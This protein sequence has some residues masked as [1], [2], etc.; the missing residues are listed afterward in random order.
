MAPIAGPPFLSYL[1]RQ[2]ERAGFTKA[3]LCLGYGHEKIE[4]WVANERFQKLNVAFSVEDEP[5]G[6]AGA[7]RL[8]AERFGGD[9]D[10]FVLNGDSILQLDFEEMLQSHRQRGTLVTVA[11]AHVPDTGRYG[12]VNLDSEDHVLDF[13]EKSN[14][15]SAGHI[16]G[17]IYL[18]QPAVLQS[19]PAKGEIS[20][21][22]TVL[23]GLCP[24]NL[25]AFKA[26]GYFIDIG[27]PEDFQRAQN[28]FRELIW[29]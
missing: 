9:E 6:T 4:R 27:I 16:N 15:G 1:L 8:A 19:I 26:K 28:E 25:G 22:R 14:S 5:L 23:P 21:E 29:L 7:I 17:G 24:K 10:L 20:L 11:L 3:V 18:F 12:A 13:C 2:L